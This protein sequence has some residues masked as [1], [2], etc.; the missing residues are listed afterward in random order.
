MSEGGA[1]STAEPSEASESSAETAEKTPK[2][3]TARQSSVGAQEIKI[4]FEEMKFL[5]RGRD[6]QKAARK[7]QQRQ[8]HEERREYREELRKQ[9]AARHEHK[10]QFLKRVFGLPDMAE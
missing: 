4:F 7:E 6:E 3:K 5:Q 10:M 9:K 1:D 8:R 2:I